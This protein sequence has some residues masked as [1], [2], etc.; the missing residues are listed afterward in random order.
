MNLWRAIVLLC[1]AVHLSAPTE[2]AAAKTDKSADA[3]FAKGMASLKEGDFEAALKFIGRAARFEGSPPQYRQYYMLVRR[4]L[5][6]RK[7]IAKE[8]DPEKWWQMATSLQGFYSVHG[9]YGE[10]VALGKQMHERRP[11][12][13][14]AVILA[15][16]YLCLW[17][18]AEAERVLSGL[19]AKVMTP[20]A[21]V[22]LGI[23]QARQKK[24]DR[25]K[26]VLEQI[27]EPPRSSPQ[28]LFDLARLKVLCGDARGG[29]D[30]LTTAFESTIPAALD[31][32][33]Y[34]VKTSGDLAS[35]SGSKAFAKVLATKSKVVE[36]SCGRSDRCGSCPSRR[37]CPGS[38][39]Q[40]SPE[41]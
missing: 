13:G 9:L 18:N 25:S 37:S 2:A 31:S 1:V 28:V 10:V 34:Q 26:A 40:P 41:R 35:L 15:D 5:K 23:A 32:F 6:T 16:A 30:T 3:S 4:V 29:L 39:G 8:T 20:H 21:K 33:K 27:V 11:C 38:G 24:I 36:S 7:V 22:L 19:D 17:Q 14:S 12:V